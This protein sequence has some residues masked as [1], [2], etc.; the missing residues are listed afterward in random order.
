MYIYQAYVA[1]CACHTANLE[2]NT[3][4][5]A[6]LEQLLEFDTCT[7]GVPWQTTTWLS[8][9]N[10]L[11]LL[12]SLSG[13]LTTLRLLAGSFS[14]TKSPHTTRLART[15]T[16]APALANHLLCNPPCPRQR[17]IAGAASEL[18]KTCR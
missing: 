16:L 3:A 6:H 14:H 10:A 13:C 15:P 9:T 5:L 7:R 1:I 17:P 2:L 18:I 12:L 11:V 4:L 8:A